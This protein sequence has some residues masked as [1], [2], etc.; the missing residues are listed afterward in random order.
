MGWMVKGEGKG[1][2]F[3]SLSNTLTFA[4]KTKNMIE[5]LCKT[6]SDLYILNEWWN[7]SLSP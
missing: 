3:E 7:L 1:H 4:I 2:G 6:I 5:K